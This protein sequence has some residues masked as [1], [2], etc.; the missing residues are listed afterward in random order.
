M[1]PF[2]A[3]AS[4][5]TLINAPLGGFIFHILFYTKATLER[6]HGFVHRKFLMCVVLREK[7]E[8]GESKSRSFL[9]LNK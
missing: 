4:T 5:N 6:S 2:L 1:Y 8:G 9:T 7:N 3:S